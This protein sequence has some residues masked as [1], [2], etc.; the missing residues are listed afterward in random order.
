MPA[1]RPPARRPAHPRPERPLAPGVEVRVHAARVLDAVVHRGRSLKSELAP[2]LP[3]LADPRD[4]ALLEA[5]VFAA[6][7]GRHRYEA[8]LR[9]WLA[10]PPGAGDGSL[11][12]LLLAGCAQLDALQL[13]AHAALD[14]TVEAARAL[15][16]PHQAGLVNALLRRAQREGFPAA[17]PAAAWPQWLRKKVE[18]AWPQH[19]AAVFAA[20]AHAAPLWL[21]VNRRLAGREAYRARL[22]EAG[23]AASI[24]PRLVDGLRLDEPVPVAALPGFEEGLVAVQDGSAQQAA[25]ALAPEPGARVLDACAAPGGKAAHLLER[26]PTLELLALD[27]D[28]RRLARVEDTLRRGGLLGERVQL[29]PVDATTPALW[30]DG[31]TFDAILLDAPCSATGVVRRQPDIL[32]HRRPED[33]E[34]LVAAQARL[35]DAVW[36][37]LRPGG[38]LLYATCSI[39]PEENAGQVE[40]FLARTP[41]AAAVPLPEAFGHAAGPGRQ[42]LTG[43]DGMDG[44]FYARLRKSE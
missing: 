7:R 11:V 44:F 32:L 9:G 26:D 6:L 16:R 42:R 2:V 5:V 12:A 17:D 13:P 38:I 37:L 30:W 34:S 22:Q 8:A 19:A 21:R 18:A 36:P 35:L 15:G 10:R 31:F 24:D 29:R 41:D 3:R 25:D 43:E 33:I 40:A 28:P 4:R 20:S 39:L 1:P 14:A 27:V 23:I